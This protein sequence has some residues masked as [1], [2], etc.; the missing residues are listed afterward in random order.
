[1]NEHRLR[2]KLSARIRTAHIIE[3]QRNKVW[4]VGIHSALDCRSPA[5]FEMEVALN[6]VAQLPVYYQGFSPQLPYATIS[7]LIQPFRPPAEQIF[8]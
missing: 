5:Q 4:R 3:L 2:I 6:A 7:V 1:M 8:V